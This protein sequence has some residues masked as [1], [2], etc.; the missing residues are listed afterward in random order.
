MLWR[1]VQRPIEELPRRIGTI[2]EFKS[3]RA[4]AIRNA[5]S[6]CK[7]SGGFKIGFARSVLGWSCR[8][9]WKIEAHAIDEFAADPELEHEPAQF[10]RGDFGSSRALL[11][12]TQYFECPAV[13]LQSN[14]YPA[15]GAC[16][17]WIGQTR[18]TWGLRLGGPLGYGRRCSG[19]RLG[20]GRIGLGAPGATLVGRGRCYRRRRRRRR[21]TR[22][23]RIKRECMIVRIEARRGT[24][25]RGAG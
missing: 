16:G 13:E 2:D 18:T 21:C 4:I 14:I 22:R 6:C 20:A 8:Q 17:C 3:C 9:E 15:I 23:W 25:D 19:G 5:N 10:A 1:K 12:G 24:R 7:M 11:R